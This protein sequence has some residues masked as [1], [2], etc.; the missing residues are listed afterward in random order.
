MAAR[1]RAVAWSESARAALDEVGDYIAQDSRAG[2]VRVLERAL[3]VAASLGTL[4]DRGRVV[5]EIGDL[6]IRELPVFR[7]RLMYLVE[8]E[9]VVVLAFVHGARDFAT[10]RQEQTDK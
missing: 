4:A 6:S 9:R 7:Y 8:A 3:A 5:P 2:A 1:T 10:W